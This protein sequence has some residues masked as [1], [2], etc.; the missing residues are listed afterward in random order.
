MACLNHLHFKSSNSM[1]MVFTDVVFCRSSFLESFFSIGIKTIRPCMKI[2]NVCIHSIVLLICFQ[3]RPVG[4]PEGL[5]PQLAGQ[6]FFY[7]V[8]FL[9]GGH[10]WGWCIQIT[11]KKTMKC[12]CYTMLS[13]WPK[14]WSIRSKA[15]EK[16]KNNEPAILFW[17]IALSQSSMILINA[18]WQERCSLKQ[19]CLK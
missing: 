13:L 15:L 18:V 10:I 7:Y 9:G 3:W 14:D 5:C 12:Q 8:F 6:Y 11:M 17:L 4:V 16:S 19:D 2:K 1:P